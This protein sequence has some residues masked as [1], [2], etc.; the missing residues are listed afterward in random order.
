MSAE[1]NLCTERC[2]HGGRTREMYRTPGLF[3]KLSERWWIGG[4]IPVGL[5]AGSSRLGVMVAAIYEF[6]ALPVLQ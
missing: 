1:F 2:N 5:D 6:N 4:G 3:R